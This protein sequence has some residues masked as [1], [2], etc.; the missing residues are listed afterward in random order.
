MSRNNNVPKRMRK[1][2]KRSNNR[3]IQQTSVVSNQFRV[4]NSAIVPARKVV[5][6]VYN[7]ATL[8][9]NNVGAPYLNFFMRL[10]SAYDPDPALL[11]G[12]ISG[13]SEWAKFYGQYRVLSTHITWNVSNNETF[14][15][16]VGFLATPYP[17]VIGSVAQAIDALENGVSSGPVL[18][19]A[20]SGQDNVS[21]TRNINLP[22]VWGDPRNYLFDDGFA[23]SVTTNPALI[24]EGSFIAYAPSVFSSGITSSLRL[25]MKVLFYQRVQLFG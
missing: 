2:P 19:S 5:T 3:Q 24:I 7:D 10:N 11:S 17:I 18:L 22:R 9:R 12:G 4:K 1:R 20:K 15:V 13:F 6:L 25:V 14:P 21:L 23:A 8:T 16:S